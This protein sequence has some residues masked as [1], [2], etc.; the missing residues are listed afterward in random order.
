MEAALAYVLAIDLIAATITT[1]A[2]RSTLSG[3]NSGVRHSEWMAFAVLAVASTLHLAC[4]RS[5]APTRTA[6]NTVSD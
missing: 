2:V 4:S 1:L 5:R 3:P 6:A